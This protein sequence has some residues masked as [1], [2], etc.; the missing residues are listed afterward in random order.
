[1]AASTQ[2]LFFCI[3]DLAAIEP[4][5]QYSLKWFNA[6]FIKSIKDSEKG[7][8]ECLCAISSFSSSQSTY[9]SC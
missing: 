1:M 2:V 4:T 5:Y 9:A 8:G 7:S 6:L 3:A